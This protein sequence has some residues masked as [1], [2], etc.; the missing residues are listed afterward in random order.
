MNSI[1]D[2]YCNCIGYPAQPSVSARSNRSPGFIRALSPS[3]HRPSNRYLVSW[4]D[5]AKNSARYSSAYHRRTTRTQK[6]NCQSPDMQKNRHHGSYGGRCRYN[7]GCR[8]QSSYCCY[9]T[10]SVIR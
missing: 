7:S 1:P 8:P 6:S 3:Q 4:C 10:D 2:Q 9:G 5:P